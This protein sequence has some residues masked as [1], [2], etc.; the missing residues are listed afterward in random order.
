M[1]DAEKTRPAIVRSHDVRL[2]S[3]YAK[4]IY[5]VKARYRSTQIKAALKVNSE[6]LLFYWELGRDL[7]LKKVEEAWGS[8]VVEQVSLDL[9][10]EFPDAKGFSV[11]NLWYMKKWYLFYAED[12]EGGKLLSELDLAF[13]MGAEK[14]RQVAAI[15]NATN[16]G[17]KLHQSGAEIAFPTAFGF[18]PW[19]H[20]VEVITKCDSVDE[21]LFYV[22]K[23]IEESLSRNALV[24][25]IGANLYRSEGSALSNFAERLPV[26]QGR[27]AQEIVKDSYDLGFITLPPEYSERDLEAALEQNITRF[28]LE[29]GTGFAFVGRQK[30]IIV[31]GKTRKV[32]MLFYHIRLRCYVVVE[33]KAVSFEPEFVGKLNFYVNAVDRLLRSDGDN[34]TIGLLICKDRNR[35]EVQWAFEGIQTPMGVA[36]Y[37]NVTIEEMRAHLP[38]NEQIQRRIEQ[39]EEEFNLNL[40]NGTER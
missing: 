3:D 25:S 12:A 36:T 27:L 2:D 21:A 17:I 33:L 10:S 29:L 14:L 39:A 9:Q 30:E 24:N 5:A 35:T 40:K 18:V 19:R 26:S 6:L 38:T 32:D 31:S 7:A 4:W 15:T 1:V 28:L 20:H 22:R 13:D 8:G 16:L 11:R 37:G 34:P 23:T